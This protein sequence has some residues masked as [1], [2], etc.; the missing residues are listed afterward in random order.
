MS[1]IQRIPWT[2]QPQYPVHVGESFPWEMAWNGATPSHDLVTSRQFTRSASLTDEAFGA[3]RVVTFT[4][5]TLNAFTRAGS[6]TTIRSRFTA[7][8]VF[9]WV[10]GASNNFPALLGSSTGNSGYRVSAGDGAGTTL[11]MVKGSVVALSTVTLTSNVVYAMVTSHDTTSGDY[12]MLC[13][14]VFGGAIL[15]ATQTNTSAS[16]AGNGNWG[17]GVARTDVGLGAFNGSIALAAAGYFYIPEHIGAQ[18]LNNPWQ[19]FTPQ[20]RRIWVDVSAAGGYNITSDPAAFSLT[21]NPA[22]LNVSRKATLSAGS[23]ALTGNAAGL[24]ASRKLVAA[25][26]SYALT[27][28]AVNLV[29]YGSSRVLTVA[30]GTFSLTGN[31]VGLKA[32]RKLTSASSAFA[33]TGNSAGLKASR[34]LTSATAAYALTCNAVAFTYGSGGR[35]ITVETGNFVLTGLPVILSVVGYA[36]APSGGGYSPKSVNIQTRPDAKQFNKR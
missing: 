17:V 21:G 27:G 15:R 26:A 30:T 9:R 29:Y 12:Y 32:A 35:R 14:P 4:G 13:R 23:F 16:A 10:S 25:T 34:K 3:G 24:K 7:L 11:G 36:R 1:I 31:S 22:G 28:N 2:V 8:S 19:I 33:L 6:G 18:L 20:P 5:N